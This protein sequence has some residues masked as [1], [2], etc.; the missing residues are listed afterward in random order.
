MTHHPDARPDDGVLAV[1]DVSEP[2]RRAKEILRQRRESLAARD[3]ASREAAIAAENWRALSECI[4][5]SL[6]THFPTA[7]APPRPAGWHAATGDYELWLSVPG[8]RRVATRFLRLPSG[9]WRWAQI[10]DRCSPDDLTLG[11][12]GRHATWAAQRDDGTLGY[13]STLGMALLAAELPA[14]EA[15]KL[16]F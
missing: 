9:E 16:P 12:E 5:R 2:D 8:H 11:S 15:D 14:G 1:P 10:N 6:A 3:D 4:T 7:A 13:F